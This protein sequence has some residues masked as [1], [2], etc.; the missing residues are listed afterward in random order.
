MKE[1]LLY[2]KIE[3]KGKRIDIFLA[4]E[5]NLTRSRIKSLIDSDKVF[6]ND[7]VV[8]KSGFDLKE[9]CIKVIID[10][11]E[12]I[13]A[14]PENIPLEI[15]YEDSDIAVINKPQGMV[16]HPATGSP[17][18]TLVNA[19]MYH[20]KDLSEINGVYR[21]GIVHRLDKDTSGL[22]VIAKN[23]ASHLSL[24]K[25]I[26]E[27]TAK[28][29]YLALVIGNIK[30]DEG[31]ID[32]PI[33][34]HRTNRKTMAVDESGRQAITHFKTLERFMDYTFM[35]FELKTGRTHQI[36]V[37][38]KYINHPVVGDTAYGCKDDFKLNGQ[39]LHAYKLVIN[40]PSTGEVITFEAPLPDYFQ[41]T[42]D[43]LRKKYYSL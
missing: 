28:R 17:S 34:R 12:S 14:K 43:K 41:N 31:V 16:T 6:F 36:R 13:S 25:Q 42:L 7:K 5:I 11:P 38:A 27:K 29:Y 24:A 20:I 35:E 22:I 23:N 37:H 39:L 2:P 19:A 33:A 8:K 10:Q 21:P 3:D 9:G 26:S 18:K 30:E 15:V 32:K 1:H 4:E 40:H